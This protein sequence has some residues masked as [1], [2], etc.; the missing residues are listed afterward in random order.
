VS[1]Q[2]VE[3]GRRA[4][5][6]PARRARRSSPALTA[7][8]KLFVVTGPSG[9]GKGTIIRALVGSRPDL[10]L[11]VSAT[12]R[13]RRPGE[14]DGREYYFLNDE[15]FD[16]RLAESEFLEYVTFPWHQRSGTLYSE[17][18]RIAS[19]GHACLLELEL[20]GAVAVKDRVEG[21][22]TIFVDAPLPELERR[23]RERA[24]ESAGEIDERLT[25]ARQQ[26]R[27]AHE[28][29]HVVVNDDLDR[30]VAEL[31]EIVDHETG[32]LPAT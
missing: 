16:R 25:L 14:V 7:P 24:T 10:E 1:D 5:G 21:S 27:L 22:V 2:P 4:V 32:R 19:K 13:Q 15:E 30:A 9:A 28:F 3:D 17:V 18:E 8:P 6:A 20:H 23:L 29:D 31:E 26:R 12:T 11:A